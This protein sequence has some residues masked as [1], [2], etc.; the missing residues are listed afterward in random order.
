M[1]A[2]ADHRPWPLPRA[3]WIAKMVWKKLLFAHWPL[4]P[5]ALRPL[6]PEPLEIDT[7]GGRAWIAVVPFTMTIAP[8]AA[9]FPPL[10]RTFHEL[11]VRTYVTLQT[12][13]GP[14]PGV[15]FFSLDCADPFSVRTA[16]AA[17]LPYYHAHMSMAQRA[18]A[19]IHYQSARH[20]PPY[21]GAN[22]DITY[23][24]TAPAH[25]NTPDT[26]E[27]FLT[28]RYCLYCPATT[29]ARAATRAHEHNLPPGAAPDATPAPIRRIDIHHRPWSLAPARAHI[30]HNTMCAPLALNLQGPPLLHY[31]HHL[32][33]HTW[34]PM[35]V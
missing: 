1:P 29:A 18:E 25:I 21:P 7:F 5:A 22:L 4:D 10:R 9:P 14:R 6:I 35:R 20:H 31:A 32:E 27:S 28:E 17:G 16:R 26:I 24:P 11:N 34:P 8:R 30:E 15:W 19:A 33:V 23:A 13:C 3:P 12:P 2:P